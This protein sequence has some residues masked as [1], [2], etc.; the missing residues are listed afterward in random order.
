[1]GK[2]KCLS[3]EPCVK[4]LKVR[5][6]D[7]HAPVLRKMA[8]EVNHVWNYCNET[9]AHGW[10]VWGK[11]ATGFDMVNNVNGAC[12]H[13]NHIGSSTITEVA[14]IHAK[15]RNQFKKSKL[16]WRTSKPDAK[17]RSLGWIPFNNRGAR[18][19]NGQVR[20]AGRHF[21]V[22]DSYG[23][24]RHEFRAGSF[25]EDSRGR[26]H[27][28]VA[29]R[30]VPAATAKIAVPD[31]GI[32]LGL[33]DAATSCDGTSVECR[34]YRELEREIGVQQRARNKKR[35]AALHAKV[36]NRRKDDQH[37]FTAR[38]VKKAGAIFVGD[39]KLPASKSVHDVSWHSLK[40]MLEYKCQQAGVLYAVGSERNSTRTRSSCG[41]IPASRPKGGAGL[42]VRR[43]T[44]DECGASH[45]RDVNVA[46]NIRRWG[47]TWPSVAGISALQGGDGVKSSS[48][49]AGVRRT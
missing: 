3:F 4:T 25:V 10:R 13:Y 6:R 42:G 39:V 34:R 24:G 5:V 41:A 49:N 33:K 7:K 2:R 27:F 38:L 32:D 8:S 43:W 11:W 28:C 9:S 14:L 17:K 35:V 31:I 40:R 22:W 36:R 45:R 48:E 18:W 44:C 47:R 20:F 16:A 19:S 46:I 15:A 29:V 30:F 12:E 21:K 26:W 37:K 1:M 23:L